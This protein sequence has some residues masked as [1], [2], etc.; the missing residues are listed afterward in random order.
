M[1]PVNASEFR[2]IGMS[3]SGNHCVIDWLLRQA[4]GRYCFLN[5]A[6][7]KSNPFVT[8]RALEERRNLRT[9]ISGF[10]VERERRG[11]FSRKDWLVH[12][13]EDAFLGHALS[14]WFEERHDRLVGASGHRTDLLLLRDPFNL[15]ASRRRAGIGLSAHTTRRVWMQHARAFADGSPHLRHRTVRVSYNSFVT[16]PA[17]RAGIARALGLPGHD[18][19]LRTVSRCAGG[20]SFD[21]L[22][23]DGRADEMS[24]TDRWRHCI[25]EPD[26][27]ALFDPELVA[28]ARKTFPDLEVP[29]RLDAPRRP[30]GTMVPARAESDARSLTPV[31]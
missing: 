24:V 6:E 9:N 1:Q 19:G 23:L 26:Y 14:P 18:C 29:P 13:Y 17:Y 10:S 2:V 31:G 28:L 7:G 4:P 22:R 30:R 11:A 20:S 21:G 25:D 8:A 12:S 15:F 16:S 27:R 5:C 3:R